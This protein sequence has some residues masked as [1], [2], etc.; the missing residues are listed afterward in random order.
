ML[1]TFTGSVKLL[2]VDIVAYG[3]VDAVRQPVDRAYGIQISLAIPRIQCP[4]TRKLLGFRQ[5]FLKNLFHCSIK[6]F[7]HGS[8]CAIK[9]P[10]ASHRSSLALCTRHR[11]SLTSFENTLRHTL[12]RAQH[13]SIRLTASFKVATSVLSLST[14]H[15]SSTTSLGSQHNSIEP[16][17]PKHLLPPGA[18]AFRTF[19]GKRRHQRNQQP[20]VDC[21]LAQAFMTTPKS[22]MRK[23]RKGTSLRTKLSAKAGQRRS[24]MHI[25]QNSN[26]HIKSTRGSLYFAYFDKPTGAYYAEH[27]A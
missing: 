23:R 13:H 4:S 26:N 21:W 25:G 1:W 9:I 3:N 5:C 19:T 14:H 10:S 15:H 16:F 2:V 8:Q 17:Q 7:W 24:Q 22:P 11:S 20:C 27:M 12:S 18:L 6:L